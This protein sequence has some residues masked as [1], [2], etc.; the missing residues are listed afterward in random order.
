MI[1]GGQDRRVVREPARTAG[2]E[3]DPERDLLVALAHAAGLAGRSTPTPSVP[4]SA[5]LRLR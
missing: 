3:P 4:L 2:A 5:P 1:L